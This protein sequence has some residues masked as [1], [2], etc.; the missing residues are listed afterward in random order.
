MSRRQRVHFLLTGEPLLFGHRGYSRLAPE[1]TPAAFRRILEHGIPGVELDVQ[2]CASGEPVVLHDYSLRRTCGLEARVE[3]AP[4]GLLR[5]LDAGAWFGPEHRG[6]RIPLLGEVFE[7]LGRR[8]YYDVEL[9]SPYRRSRGLEAAVLACIARHGLQDCCL[10]SSFNP[11]CLREVER[12]APALPTALIYSRDREVP[13]LLRRGAGRL[14]AR[15]ALLKPEHSLIRPRWVRFQRARRRREVIGWTVDDPA[16]AER[17]VGMGVRGLV[18]N[19]PAR[20]RAAM[21]RAAG[22]A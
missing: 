17:L 7:L 3:Q 19:D 9:K 10:V 16:T 15:P 20:I 11:F 5:E 14:L 8:V 18:S 21:E 6:E 4:W 12:L 13:R 2:L 22:R 1:N